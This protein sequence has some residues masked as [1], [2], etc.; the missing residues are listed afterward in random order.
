VR[1]VRRGARV[2]VVVREGA[3]TPTGRGGKLHARVVFYA[4]VVREGCSPSPY[5]PYPYGVLRAVVP[6]V[7][8]ELE[9]G[10][11]LD[12][13]VDG[14]R[15]GGVVRGGGGGV[16]GGRGMAAR[17]DRRRGGRASIRETNEQINKQLRSPPSLSTSLYPFSLPPLPSFST[18]LPRSG[19]G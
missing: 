7:G 3:P 6:C 14:V 13:G 10:V 1:V 17:G 16:G 19:T 4:T 12:A 2:L 8:R 15:D 11:V 18:S 9:V 5:P